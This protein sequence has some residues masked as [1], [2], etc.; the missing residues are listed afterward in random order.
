MKLE[1]ANLIKEGNKHMKTNFI[2]YQ[3]AVC[4]KILHSW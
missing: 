1:D 4:F 2:C 3:P